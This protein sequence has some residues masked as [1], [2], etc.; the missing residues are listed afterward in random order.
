MRVVII[1]KAKLEDSAAILN[2]MKQLIEEHAAV[3]KYYKPFIKY[4]GLKKYIADAIKNRGQL[5]LIAECDGT[6]AGYLMAAIEE[7]P[8]YSSEKFI[9]VIADTA[10]DKKYRRQGILKSLFNETLGWLKEKNINY[11]ELSVDARNTA[12]VAAWRKFGFEDYKLR[13]RRAL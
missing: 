10:V 11:L 6:I 13:L 12:A 8:F 3:D 2:L 7:A 5:L 9:G 4:R 1:R